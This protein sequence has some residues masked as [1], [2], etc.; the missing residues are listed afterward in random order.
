MQIAQLVKSYKSVAVTT[1]T[2]GQLVLML[3]DGALRF[4]A[5]AERG[6]EEEDLL[7]RN[8]AIHNNIIRAQNILLELQ[9]SLD[10]RVEGGFPQRMF[11]LYDFMQFQLNQANIKKE[12]PPIRIV[13][14]MLGE[15]RD[16]WAQMLEKSANQAR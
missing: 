3:F 1:A 16:A 15:I 7:R 11:A 12:V 8:E 14:G 5:A 9:Y 4:M 2:P 10:L 6:F 13:S